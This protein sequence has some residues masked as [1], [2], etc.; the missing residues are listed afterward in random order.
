MGPEKENMKGVLA[1]LRECG[2]SGFQGPCETEKPLEM[3]E[4]VLS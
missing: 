3:G 4:D 1:I 2:M